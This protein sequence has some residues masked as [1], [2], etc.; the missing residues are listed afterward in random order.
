MTDRWMMLALLFTVRLSMAFQFQS[1]GAVAPT[2]MSG[3]S[4]SIAD[5]GL[6][7]SLYLSPGLVFALPGGE[8]GRRFGDRPVVMFGLALMLAG[9]LLMAFGATW[10]AQLAGRLIA[11][12]GGVLINVLMSKMVT[13]WFAGREIASAMAIFINS[14]PIGIAL[15][16]VVL[17]SVATAYGVIGVHLLAAGL[18]LTG[19]A[20][21]CRYRSPPGLAARS[22]SAAWPSGQ[23]LAMVV[24]AGCIW[25]FYNGAL[26]MVFG[27]GTTM[28]TERG[29]SL[30]AAGSATSLV[31][32][33]VGLSVPLGGFFADRF[34]RHVAV[35]LGGFGLF[36]AALVLATR[37]DHVVAAFALLGLASG[38][39]AGPIMSL[40]AKVLRE[41]TR[42]AGMG[43]Y[44]ALFYLVVIAAPIAA[45]ALAALTRNS[46]VAFDFGAAMLTMCFL[47]FAVYRRLAAPNQFAS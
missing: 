28:L 37:T 15:A 11:G 45:G 46:S 12:I 35:M 22:G 25:G 10:S 30:A 4:A 26:A 39:P 33:L 7:I 14:W 2:I 17:P 41:N 44:F 23:A 29:W 8:I 40:P 20:L 18:A 27:F 47:L 21:M 13:D 36:A 34:D 38:L 43:I 6:L 19:L 32:W 24:V 5:I 9:G 3:Y 42:A 1:I 16:L 31:L